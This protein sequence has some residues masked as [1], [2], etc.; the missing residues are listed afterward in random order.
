M[1]EPFA[2]CGDDGAAAEKVRPGVSVVPL[3]EG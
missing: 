3:E 2:D 1:G